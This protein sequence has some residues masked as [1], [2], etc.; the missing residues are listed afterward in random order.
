[1]KHTVKLARHLW[2]AGIVFGLASAQLLRAQTNAGDR[3]KTPAQPPV[4]GDQPT[5]APEQ[6][7][8]AT[9]E[10][11]APAAIGQ[12]E[13]CL[14]LVSFDRKDLEA[15]ARQSPGASVRAVDVLALWRAGKGRLVTSSTTQSTL[16][17]QMTIK[18]VLEWRYPQSYEPFLPSTLDNT[19]SNS[20]RKIDTTMPII[21]LA[22]VDFQT[23]EIGMI[24]ICN[25]TWDNGLKI[26]D[27]TMV[28]ELTTKEEPEE[29]IYKHVSPAGTN[30]L[31]IFQ[32]AFQTKTVTVKARCTDGETIVYNSDVLNQ[33]NDEMT[34]LLI[35]PYLI[36]P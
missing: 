19:S 7:K 12:V 26:F 36:H 30:M 14:S 13:V 8:P 17:E 11:C 27:M 5:K 18:D 25:V 16:G 15:V 33:G 9:A 20:T 1:M 34:Y 6:A 28:P 2:L 10:E 4:Q 35:T 23:R 3:D 32:P 22:P 31:F 21:T 24:F 29:P